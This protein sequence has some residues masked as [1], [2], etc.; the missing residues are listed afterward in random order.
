M[1]FEKATVIKFVREK[2]YGFV[3]TESGDELYFRFKKGREARLGRGMPW[4]TSSYQI[5]RGRK[6]LRIP[7]PPVGETIYVSRCTDPADG[8]EKVDIWLYGY[9]YTWVMRR[10]KRQPTYKLVVDG[11]KVWQGSDLFQLLEEHSKSRY[12]DQRFYTQQLVSEDWQEC[13]DPRDDET[14]IRNHR[15]LKSR[16]QPQGG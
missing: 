1:N 4:I 2:L 8:R 12:A 13:D 11:E 3:R 9:N 15:D 6:I 14:V 10:L 5:Q 7:K 16:F